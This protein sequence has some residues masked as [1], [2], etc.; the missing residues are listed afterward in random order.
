MF[1]LRLQQTLDARNDCE[2][3]PYPLSMSIGVEFYDYQHPCSIQDLLQRADLQM[4]EQKK[5]R[6]RGS[7]P[8]R[9]R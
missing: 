9:G 8:T 5:N 1:V 2:G 7:A 3:M 4:Y 6:K